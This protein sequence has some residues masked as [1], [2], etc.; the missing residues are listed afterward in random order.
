MDKP[1]MLFVDS[2]WPLPK[3]V[4]RIHVLLTCQKYWQ[5][6]WGGASPSG[7][8]PFSR[9]CFFLRI[10]FVLLEPSYNG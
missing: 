5:K 3:S 6:I 1:R 8:G 9:A 10:L 7:N 2:I 4:Y